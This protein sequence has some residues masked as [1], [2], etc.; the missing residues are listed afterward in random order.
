M[1]ITKIYV[2][3]KIFLTTIRDAPISLINEISQSTL[4]IFVKIIN[5][6]STYQ[7]QPNRKRTTTKPRVCFV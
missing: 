6:Y 4:Y 7:T 5:L 1:P 2:N 3:R